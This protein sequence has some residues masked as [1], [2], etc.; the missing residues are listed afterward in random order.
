MPMPSSTTTPK[1][2]RIAIWIFFAALFSQAMVLMRFSQSPHFLPSSDDM[3]FYSD[4]AERIA[5]G[6]LTDGK[7][8]YGLPGYAYLLALFYKVVG[9]DPFVVA[10]FQTVAFA[11]VATVIFLVAVA[12]HARLRSSD[13]VDS[14]DYGPI[15]TGIVA[16]AGW[17]FFI[18]AQT[19]SVIL[20]P[21]VLVVLAY[22]GSVL[23]LMRKEPSHSAW[24]WFFLGVTVGLV[25]MVVATIFFVLP[26]ALFAI[27]KESMGNASRTLA[28]RLTTAGAACVAIFAGV[29]L[30][31]SPAAIHNYL[32]AREP[33]LLSAHS[34]LNLWIGN[35]PLAN[36]YPKIPPGLRASQEG[37]LKDSIS[38]AQSASGRP[39]KRY[40]VS[41]YWSDKANEWIRNNRFAW[42]RLL[43]VKFE[44][45]WNAYQY[46]D[47][48]S[49]KL[50]QSAGVLLPGLQFGLVSAL[51][52]PGLLLTAYRL[53]KGRWIVAAVIL[54]ML[55]MLSVFVTERYRLAAVPGLL[56]GAS[57]LIYTF[58]DWVIHSRWL[59]V[60][61]TAVATLAS[62]FYVTMPRH[63]PGFWSLDHYKGGIR[64][65]DLGEMTRARTELETAYAYASKN[66][67][68]NFALGNYWLTNGNLP[69]AKS[70]YRAA[71][72]LDGNHA[73]AFNNLGVI[74][75]Q[76]RQW[77]WAEKLLRKALEI[78]PGD[79]KAH[80]L[81]ATALLE[82]G[83]RVGAREEIG[84]ALRL[85]PEQPEFVAL[86]AKLDA[87]R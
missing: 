80:Y 31:I 58:F 40:E 14:R 25:A 2:K 24:P 27:A 61:G 66:A 5:G 68:I 49:I 86:R 45:F 69:Q 34:G 54:H 16:A 32:I 38:L 39:L 81:L 11:G 17:L 77:A 19:F 52:I 36:G 33:V 29:L 87:Q 37:L 47:L 7:A 64:A 75:L 10:G 6:Q 53:P 73:S 15:A 3:K 23:W 28:K 42:L 65:L 57:Y 8:F 21:T 70:F 59:R 44:N 62:A 41:K 83:N 35:N 55:A 85:R 74:M 84:E 48:S 63:D 60:T 43:G 51:G 67:E 50:L 30:G 79:A 1:V 72:E 76:E 4:W 12:A 13:E 26:M 22:W 20:M 56:I 82:S 18:P 78:E 46:D 9:F 71:L